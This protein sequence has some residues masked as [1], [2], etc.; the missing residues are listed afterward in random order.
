MFPYIARG[1]MFCCNLSVLKENFCDTQTKEAKVWSLAQDTNLKN[2]V[3]L[4]ILPPLSAFKLHDLIKHETLKSFEPF[5]FMAASPCAPAYMR[6]T[7]Q[8][9]LP[10]CVWRCSVIT[11]AGIWFMCCFVV[12]CMHA[13]G[14]KYCH[15]ACSMT[16]S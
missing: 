11:C 16:A 14:C 13:Y 9:V 15:A 10:C 3:I 2:V 7:G 8:C 12:C 6:S 4:Y 5:T 1:L